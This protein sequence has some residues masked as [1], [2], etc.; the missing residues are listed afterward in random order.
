L[1]AHKA[2]ADLVEALRMRTDQG[3]AAAVVRR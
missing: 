1:A 3:S 2:I